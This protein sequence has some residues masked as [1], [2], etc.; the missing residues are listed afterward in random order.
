MKESTQPKIK[1]NNKVKKT[2][3]R[4][5]EVEVMNLTQGQFAYTC[6]KTMAR[7]EMTGYGDTEIM[8]IEQLNVMKNSH[9]G[10]LEKFWIGIVGVED[11][12]ITVD[13]VLIYLR[14]DRL[15]GDVR[16]EADKL[17]DFIIESE[18]EEFI[19]KIQK[20]KP[21]LVVILA[22]RMKV[23]NIEGEFGDSYKMEAVAKRMGRPELF[24][25]TV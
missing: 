13:D 12:D 25:K 3:D 18:R 4:N 21:A 8:T 16:F 23:L 20:M 7:I 24:N 17:D 2:I 15:Y 1:K 6:P 22:Q 9:K 5:L 10:I 11:E 14:L 19:E